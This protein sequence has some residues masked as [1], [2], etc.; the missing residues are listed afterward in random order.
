MD[1][2]EVG[3]EL[4]A[5]VR[6]QWLNYASAIVSR[7]SPRHINV[8]GLQRSEGPSENRNTSPGFGEAVYAWERGN[9]DDLITY[10]RSDRP[11]AKPDRWRLIDGIR[12]K[13]VRP[14][15]RPER[16]LPKFAASLALALYKE[17]CSRNRNANVSSR[18]YARDMQDACANF[19]AGILDGFDADQIRELMNDKKERRA[20]EPMFAFRPGRIIPRL[21][22]EQEAYQ[23]KHRR[24]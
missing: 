15:H 6:A 20:T 12:R 5:E 18:G 2:R 1:W 23:R 19:I 13:S 21:K 7:S 11:I 22:A 4:F 24:K 9:P 14:N 8:P 3:D 10:L 17:W 16:P